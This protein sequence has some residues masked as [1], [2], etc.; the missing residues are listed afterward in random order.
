MQQY[1][2]T[3][4]PM[5]LIRNGVAV[6]RSEGID[7]A[8]LLTVRYVS[9]RLRYH[10]RVR[11]LPLPLAHV[12]FVLTASWVRLTVAT[13][14]RLF[15]N[16]Y[17][18]ADPY[19][20]LFVD[21]DRITR[22]SGLHDHKRRGWVREG[23]WDRDCDRFDEQPIPKSIRQH[24]TAD[25]PWEQTPLADAYDDPDRFEQK[26]ARIER[27][28]SEIE[29]HGFRPQRELVTESPTA[30]WRNANA[31]IAPQTNEIT[32]DIGRDGELLWNMLGKHRLSIAQVLDVDRVPV[33]VFTRHAEWH[34]LRTRL[35]CDDRS[36]AVDH[37][38][39]QGVS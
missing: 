27:L 3:R 20:V 4:Q 1:S 14:H 10:D 35:N 9:Y 13:L 7:R 28:Y 23:E 5:S 21:P 22:I 25:T 36:E 37:P 24:F 34:H 26:C 15:P 33:L 6:V 30:A 16:K 38:D 8:L 17:T 2:R 12:L 39:L 19:R 32:I 11:R 29:Q 31:T 18:D